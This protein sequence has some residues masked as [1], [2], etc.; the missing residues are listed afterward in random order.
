MTVMEKVKEIMKSKGLTATQVA[1]RT[2]VPQKTMIQRFCQK[3]ISI[4][5]LNEMLRVMDY[6]LVMVP[7][8]TPKKDGWYE[9]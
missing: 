4:D 2:G 7:A 9:L 3:N 1:A 5:K 6:K 8:D